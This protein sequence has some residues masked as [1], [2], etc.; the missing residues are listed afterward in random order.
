MNDVG[1]VAEKGSVEV[2]ELMAV[3]RYSHFLHDAMP[4]KLIAKNRL[5]DVRFA[6][7]NIHFPVSEENLKRAYRRIVFEEFFTLQ[8]AI[9]LRKKDITKEAGLSHKAEGK[10]LD[11]LK[12]AIPFELTK[13]QANAVKQIEE[14][15][16]GAKPMNRLLQGD[17]GSG[18]TVVAAHAL[19]LTVQNGFQG[20]IMVPTELLAEQHYLNLSKLLVPFGIDIALL[21]NSV[22]ENAKQDIKQKIKQGEIDIV[23]GTHALIQEGVE[24]NK[25]G[26]CVIDEQHK[27]G[28]TQR[29]ILRKKGL[30]PHVLVM[31]ATP[32]P[33]TLALTVYGDL[34]VSTI[35]ELP[36]GRKPITTYLVENEKSG[37]VYNF[38]K[39][40][41]RAGRPR[42]P[43]GQAWRGRQAYIVYPR[44]HESKSGEV[45]AATQMYEKFKNEIF[46]DFK[47]GLIHG[48]MPANEKD[49]I[50]SGFKKGELDIL[51]STVVI[52]VGI[53]VPNATV[54]VIENA[55]RFGLA[56]LHQLRGRVGRGT[57][58]SYCFL[59]ADPK[60]E[61]A[62]K[63]LKAMEDTVDGFAIAEEDFQIRGPGEF[64]GTRQHG[65][66]EIRFGNI[67]SDMEIME[68]A[69]KSAFE[70]VQED[71]QLIMPQHR[72][73]RENLYRRFRG[74]MDLI[75]VG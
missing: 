32:I 2:T 24:F 62:Q 26:V 10:L 66:P 60:T 71:P 7:N 47:V 1:R 19:V 46:K 23:V 22:P 73:L 64:F 54:M 70:V 55:E 51:V 50:M 15:M 52:E 8:L 25:L 3:E 37:E 13:G 12:K 4:A 20:A 40:Q 43:I 65:L 5:V 34:D 57:H 45:L 29:D 17:V 48:E 75:H 38:V 58:D 53:D 69:R 42:P 16:K 28:V 41:A 61:D 33:R 27:F 67:L 36:P 72:L 14:D 30:N 9:A 56:Q 11:S 63:R 31:T 59:L 68:Q 21:I 39:E 35:K 44:I 18:K 6:V 74:K 49:K